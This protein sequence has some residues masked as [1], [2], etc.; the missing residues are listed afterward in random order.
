MMNLIMP[1]IAR[2]GAQ[3]FQPRE[4]TSRLLGAGMEELMLDGTCDGVAA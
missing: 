2:V 1:K 4:E 3:V